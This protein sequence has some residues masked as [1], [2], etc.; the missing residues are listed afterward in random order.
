MKWIAE[1]LDIEKDYDWVMEQYRFCK[2]TINEYLAEKDDG[3][4]ID[5]D[6]KD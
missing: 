5:E 3:K 4:Q 6:N 2:K 1:E